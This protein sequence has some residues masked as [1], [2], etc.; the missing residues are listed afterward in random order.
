MIEAYWSSISGRKSVGVAL[1]RFVVIVSIAGVGLVSLSSLLSSRWWV[2]DTFSFFRQEI[3]VLSICLA[4][5]VVLLGPS[6]LRLA[7]VGF[8]VVFNGVQLLPAGGGAGLG[9]LDNVNRFRVLSSNV[10]SNNATRELLAGVL[11]EVDPDIVALQEVVGPW[12]QYADALQGYPYSSGD[13]VPG[14]GGENSIRL[15]S[16]YPMSV[17]P[18]GIDMH[19]VARKFG[20][21]QAIR[22]L[23]KLP[24]GSEVVVYA[25]HPPTPRGYQ[26]WVFRNEYLTAIGRAADS[27]PDD[28]PVIIVGDWNTPPWSP[29]FQRVIGQSAKLIS[30]DNLFWPEATRIFSVIVGLFIGTPIDRVVT[31]RNFVNAGLRMG[32][33]FGSDHRPVFVDLSLNHPSVQSGPK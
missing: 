30:L 26:A 4:V 14:T 21:G 18:V 25:I 32:P 28:L 27:E 11:T 15:L 33:E 16:R 10:Y 7:L 17:E 31:S 12:R 6:P 9:R 19:P 8:L 3:F 2:A 22:A 29:V 1:A 5:G 20:G 24:F 13:I 23:V